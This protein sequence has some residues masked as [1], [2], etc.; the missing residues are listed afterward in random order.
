MERI[1]SCKVRSIV[2]MMALLVS[3]AIIA[4]AQSSPHKKDT[5]KKE[6]LL[7]K[8]TVAKPVEQKPSLQPVAKPH[9]A[10]KQK[11]QNKRN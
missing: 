8:G 1:S 2:M 4:H 3:T 9:P 11:D 10:G 7:K 6:T 5:T